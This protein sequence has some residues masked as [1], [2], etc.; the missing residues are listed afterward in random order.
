MKFNTAISSMMM[1]LNFVYDENK[2]S[3]DSYKNF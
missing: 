1:F 2:I 3:K